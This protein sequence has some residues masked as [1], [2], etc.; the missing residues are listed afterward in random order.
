MGEKIELDS[1]QTAPERAVSIR[2][3]KLEGAE[4]RDLDATEVF[5]QENNISPD[6]LQALL[7]DEAAVKRLVRKVDWVLLPLLAGTY[8]LQCKSSRPEYR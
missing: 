1:K 6:Y 5:L 2:H 7:D 4:A 8:V 3:G